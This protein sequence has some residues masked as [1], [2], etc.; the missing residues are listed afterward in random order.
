MITIPLRIRYGQQPLRPTGAW[1][2]PG[3]DSGAWLAELLKWETPLEPLAIYVVPR[4]PVDLRPQGILVIVPGECPAH[5]SY[6]CQPYARIGRQRPETSAAVMYLPAEARLDPDAADTEIT[7]LLGPTNN[8]YLW[9]PSC[10]LI[11]F[12]PGDRR[13]VA[14]LLEGPP[15][16][17]THWGMAKAAANFSRRLM[18][19]EPASTPSAESVLRE[20]Q[21]DIGSQSAAL[22]E[23]PPCPGE[24]LAN[25]LTRLGTAV[26]R[27]LNDLLQKTGLKADGSGDERQTPDDAAGQ[28]SGEPTGVEDEPL[29]Q[30]PAEATSAAGSGDKRG[31]GDSRSTSMGKLA[32][33]LGKHFARLLAATLVTSRVAGRGMAALMRR[34]ARL[35]EWLSGKM[36]LR[37]R[38]AGCG[39]DRTTPAA[40]SSSGTKDVAY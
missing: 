40:I 34:L 16:H 35:G 24:P 29:S 5:V 14:D 8:I 21:E 17:K 26:K 11:G 9:H 7:G 28:A 33:G 30:Q 13:S 2:I 31:E 36:K 25:P 32:R 6:R 12:E 39:Q 37:G 3:Q 22:E 18:A 20:G 19:I 10:G 38:V 4:S 15:E 27:G 23:L 1:L